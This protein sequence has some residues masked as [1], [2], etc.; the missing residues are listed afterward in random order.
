MPY[1]VPYVPMKKSS[2]YLSE[3][4][5]RRLAW[6]AR[7]EGRSRSEILRAAI[8]AYTPHSTGQGDL[9]LFD[10]GESDGVAWDQIDEAELLDG[11]GEQGLPPQGE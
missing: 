5:A 6:L 1:L 3:A 10:S 2:V 11:F 8:R 9:A 4:E 7:R